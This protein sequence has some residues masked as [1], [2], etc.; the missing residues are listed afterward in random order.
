MSPGS[1]RRASRVAR[2]SGP[3]RSCSSVWKIFSPKSVAGE[4]N[5]MPEEA[6][7]DTAPACGRCI[8]ISATQFTAGASKYPARQQ[9][10]TMTGVRLLVMAPMS[11][12]VSSPCVASL[13]LLPCP[14]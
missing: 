8:S 5:G 4:F 6:K 10:A 2:P 12:V 3:S 11:V 13:V 1:A 9:R 14:T 7:T